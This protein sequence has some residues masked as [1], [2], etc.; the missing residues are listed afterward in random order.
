MRICDFFQNIKVSWISHIP[1][2]RYTWIQC[3]FHNINTNKKQH[4]SKVNKNILST[5]KGWTFFLLF[6]SCFKYYTSSGILYTKVGVFFC[7]LFADRYLTLSSLTKKKKNKTTNY[8]PLTVLFPLSDDTTLLVD[9]SILLVFWQNIR[10][11]HFG[12]T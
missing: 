11:E 4:P 6:V 10:D 9:L 3:Y 1:T 5:T 2:S 7:V 12:H 8:I